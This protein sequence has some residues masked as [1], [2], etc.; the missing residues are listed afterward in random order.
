V[1]SLASL[2]RRE[3]VYRDGRIISIRHPWGSNHFHS[4]VETAGAV[5][6]LRQQDALGGAKLVMTAAQRGSSVFRYLIDAE[7]LDGAEPVV[8]ENQWIAS[9]EAVVFPRVWLSPQSLLRT[10]DLLMPAPVDAPEIRLYITRDASVGRGLRNESE[11]RSAL[12]GSG[13]V[14]VDPGSLPFREQIE[15]FARASHV[16]GVHGAGLTNILFR[17]PRPL[18]LLEISPPQLR[19]D[20]FLQMSMALGFRYERI[21]GANPSDDSN[22]PTFSVAT[23]DVMG[24]M[25]RWL[26]TSTN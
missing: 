16:V 3:A 24:V 4:V 6:A 21:F 18:H 7:L 23:T 1:P 15:L 5:A 13:F 12:E 26:A 10:R 19:E 17:S 22:R 11:L 20:M 25:D 2:L 9:R 8:Q 14:T